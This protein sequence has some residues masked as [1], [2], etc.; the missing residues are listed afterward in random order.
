M[1]ARRFV[2]SVLVAVAAALAS[3]NYQV[4]GYD[5]QPAMSRPAYLTSVLVHKHVVKDVDEIVRLGKCKADPGE[6]VVG[7]ADLHAAPFDLIALGV[8]MECD[9]YLQEPTDFND[10][11]RLAVA[12]H[13]IDLHCFGA[14]H[15]P[16]KGG[17]L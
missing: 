15:D 6:V 13:E 14:R 17:A 7:C 4:T 9:F 16:P 3:C 2:L 10:V 8:E 5:P 1:N 11:A 12:G